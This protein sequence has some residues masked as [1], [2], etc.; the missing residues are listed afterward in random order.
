[1][2]ERKAFLANP[3][4]QDHVSQSREHDY[5]ANNKKSG[6]YYVYPSLCHCTDE[7]WLQGNGGKKS[8]SYK[9]KALISC[10]PM[11]RTWL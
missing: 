1:M 8:F 9:S 3:K 7:L 4:H 2:V 11:R 5:S 10:I 6:D